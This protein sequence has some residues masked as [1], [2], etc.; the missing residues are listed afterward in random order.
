M[1]SLDSDNIVC[2]LC[3][4]RGAG[5]GSVIN[6]SVSVITVAY[7]SAHVIRG[8]LAKLPAG[9]EIICVDNASVDDIAAALLDLRVHRI[10]NTENIGYG[11]ACNVGASAASGEYLLF[12]NPDVRLDGGALTALLEAAERYPDCNVFMP[13]TMTANGRLWFHGQNEIDRLSSVPPPPRVRDICGDCCVRFVDGGVFMIRRTLFLEM[14]GFDEGIFLYFED[15]DLSHRLL[16]RREPLIFVNDAHAVHDVGGSV[17]KSVRS[18]I[19]RHR[20]KMKSEVY[21]RRKYGI[22]YRPFVDI[23]RYVAKIVFY[24]LTINRSRL[25][26][27]LG[28]LIGVVE[29]ILD[30][31]RTSQGGNRTA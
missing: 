22:S 21:L 17:A 18:Q 19:M 6:R 25:L 15:D 1:V 9:V 26:N 4:L 14:G 7:N 24:C 3:S 30:K 29:S 8:A 31:S 10:D 23:M 5:W 12:M 11:R 16:Q 28:R 27:S 2:V 20:S 13:R